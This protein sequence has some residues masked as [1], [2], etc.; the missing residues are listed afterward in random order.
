MLCLYCW[1]EISRITG[2]I[3]QVDCQNAS[4]VEEMSGFVR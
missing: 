2:H 4:L 1:E 3:T